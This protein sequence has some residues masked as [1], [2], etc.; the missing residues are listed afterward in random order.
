MLQIDLL[1]VREFDD[2]V[3]Y[4]ISL[5]FISYV[6]GAIHLCIFLL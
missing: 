4:G 6:L 5:G 1:I 3:H 2:K